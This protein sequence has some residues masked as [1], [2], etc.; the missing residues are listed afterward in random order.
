MLLHEESEEVVFP[1]CTDT[2]QSGA[3]SEPKKSSRSVQTCQLTLTSWASPSFQLYTTTFRRQPT[4][5]V[6]TMV[7]IAIGLLSTSPANPPEEGELSGLG[8]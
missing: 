5:R 2:N 1:N 8:L 4:T 6:V 3:M 7:G